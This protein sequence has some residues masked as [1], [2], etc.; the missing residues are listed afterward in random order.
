[1]ERTRGKKKSA[2]KSTTRCGEFESI[3]LTWLLQFYL[4]WILV[5]FYNFYATLT[6]LILHEKLD[7]FLGMQ[8]L[9]CGKKLYD[10]PGMPRLGSISH[11]NPAWLELRMKFRANMGDATGPSTSSS[12]QGCVLLPGEKKKKVMVGHWRAIRRPD[13]FSP[14]GMLL[15]PSPNFAHALFDSKRTLHKAHWERA[16]QSNL[17]FRRVIWADRRT[18]NVASAQAPWQRDKMSYS[19]MSTATFILT[20]RKERKIWQKCVQANKRK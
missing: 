8:I 14:T 2:P 1:M 9:T 5:V 10:S 15:I 3:C 11:H 18:L 6:R 4:T 20:P 19:V 16:H 12:K 17:T 13:H 7:T